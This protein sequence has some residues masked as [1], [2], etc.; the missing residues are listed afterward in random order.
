MDSRIW[1]G[2]AF[3]IVGLTVNPSHSYGP[4][5]SSWY[6]IPRPKSCNYTAQDSHRVRLVEHPSIEGILSLPRRKDSQDRS[7]RLSCSRTSLDLSVAGELGGRRSSRF[8]DQCSSVCPEK[9]PPRHLKGR[10]AR[11][12]W[13]VSENDVNPKKTHPSVSLRGTGPTLGSRPDQTAGHD[14]S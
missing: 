4:T 5:F 14:Q 7:E 1:A 9:V 11:R 2:S 3:G 12:T 13:R 6:C 10:R 8:R